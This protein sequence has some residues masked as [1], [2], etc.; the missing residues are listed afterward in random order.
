MQ[1]VLLLSRTDL[2]KVLDFPSVPGALTEAFVA[3]HSGFW[4][5]PKRITAHCRAGGLLA[6]PC[7]GGGP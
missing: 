5:T 7:G 3:E 6:M 2:E 4:D 1:D